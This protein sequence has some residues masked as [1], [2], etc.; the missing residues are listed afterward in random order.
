MK[1]LFRLP[2]LFVSIF[3]CYAATAFTLWGIYDLLKLHWIN[4]VLEG[5]FDPLIFISM[6]LWPLYEKIGLMEG[7]WIRLPTMSG[8][9]LAALLFAVLCFILGKLFEL[10]LKRNR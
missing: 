4:K 6:P 10:S 5:F 2:W 1:K 8:L 9:V 3:V 7:D